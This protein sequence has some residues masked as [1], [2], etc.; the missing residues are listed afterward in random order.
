VIEADADEAGRERDRELAAHLPNG[1]IV[2]VERDI[3]DRTY[4]I[5]TTKLHVSQLGD[6]NLVIA[7]K[8]TDKDE[9]NPV[10]YLA[11]NGIDAPTQHVIR[12]Y[13]MR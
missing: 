13:G 9:E 6:V 11:T 12:S 3:D 4:H 2:H 1:R 10:E 8:E 7:E 5:R